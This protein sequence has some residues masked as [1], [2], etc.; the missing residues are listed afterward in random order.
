[1]KKYGGELVSAGN[2]LVRQRGT[3]F[4]PGPNVGCGRDHTLFAKADGH[5]RFLTRG[6]QN[7]KFVTIDPVSS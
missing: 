4:H 7:R 5:V 6:R 3:Q 2:I 1:V